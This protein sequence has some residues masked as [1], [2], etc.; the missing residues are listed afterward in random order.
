MLT[1]KNIQV[2]YGD[3][4]A[5]SI[6]EPISF[7]SGDRIAIIGSNGAGKTTLVKSILG[8][9]N[10][11]GR[12]S[13]ELK[14]EDI[15][16][17]MQQ[18][19]Y[20][21]TMAVKY[22]METI[23]DTN[24]KKNEKLKELITFFDFDQCLNKKF[25]ALS[26]GQKQRMTIILVMFQD[27]PLVFYDEVTS[28]LDFETRQKLMEKLVEWYRDKNTTLCVVSH[29]YSELEQLANKILIL[30]NG[31]VIDFGN[32]DDLFHKYCGKTIVTV[33][34][35]EDNVVLTKQFTK[36]EAPKHLIAISCPNE[37][38]ELKLTSLLIKGNV[39]FKRSNSDIE[40]MSINAK[41]RYNER[42]IGGCENENKTA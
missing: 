18:N 17:H 10:Y 9:T 22:I 12:I 21:N 2:K 3:Q 26:G 5:L 11:E 16:A 6:T 23:L 36:L 7:Y 30:E 27:K 35:N 4:V 33:D 14:P 42:M 37:E 34:N 40:I 39:N 25:S 41:V 38:T 32:R 31:A 1:I 28:G 29:Y 19:H 20:A 13:T 8:L 15:A 24:I